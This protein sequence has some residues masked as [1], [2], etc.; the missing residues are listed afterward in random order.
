MRRFRT[1]WLSLREADGFIARHHR[2]HVPAPVS[3]IALGL[4]ESERLVGVAVLGRPLSRALDAQ[5]AIELTRLC[6]L[7][8]SRHAASALL[9]RARRVAQA[10]GFERLVTYTLPEEGGAS[11]RAAGFQADFELVGG[12]VWDTPR[13]RRNEQ[14]TP[15]ARKVRWWANLRQQRELELQGEQGNAPTAKIAP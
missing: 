10:L 8:D 12:R 6:V 13:R 11:L 1:R 14:L 5:G 3:I 9:A 4:W 7:D 15:V 2:H